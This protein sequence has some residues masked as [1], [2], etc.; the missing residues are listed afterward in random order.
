MLALGWLFYDMIDTIPKI[1]EY[2]LIINQQKRE[3]LDRIDFKENSIGQV[4]DNEA[5]EFYLRSQSYLTEILSSYQG[6]TAR[7][8]SGEKISV[9]EYELTHVLLE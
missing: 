3:L 9:T 1:E 7:T 8:S 2:N 6:G 5:D 4:A